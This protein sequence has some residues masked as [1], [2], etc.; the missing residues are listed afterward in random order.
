LHRRGKW[1]EGGREWGN[2]QAGS[3]RQ[4]ALSYY[5]Y[6][7]PDVL[8]IFICFQGRQTFAHAHEN[9][10]CGDLVE[11]KDTYLPALVPIVDMFVKC[12]VNKSVV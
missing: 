1:G 8:L 12:V 11:S 10:V 4:V 6:G 2:P 7:G 3:A 5:I 9:K